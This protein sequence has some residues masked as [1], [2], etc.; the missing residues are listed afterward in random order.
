MA[1]LVFSAHELVKNAEAEIFK[2]YDAQKFLVDKNSCVTNIDVINDLFDTKRINEKGAL[3]AS[4]L[5]PGESIL[6][7]LWPVTVF[8]KLLKRDIVHTFKSSS[9]DEIFGVVMNLVEYFVLTGI[10]VLSILWLIA[11]LIW[12]QNFSL[13]FLPAFWRLALLIYLFNNLKLDWIIRKILWFII[14]VFFY[15]RGLILLLNTFSL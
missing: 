12:V 5:T 7:L 2:A 13:Y 9:A 8:L 14:V 1:A 10:I 4:S 3:Q 11:P 15:R 6:N